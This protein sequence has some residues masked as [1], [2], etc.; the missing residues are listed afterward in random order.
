MSLETSRFPPPL[1]PPVFDGLGTLAS[2][3]GATQVTGFDPALRDADPADVDFA[4]DPAS[5][6]ITGE[7]TQQWNTTYSVSGEV[8]VSAPGLDAQVVPVRYEVTLRNEQATPAQMRA[9]HPFDPATI[10]DRTRIEV[11]GRDYAGTPLEA[12]F[13][14]LA[15]ANGL[16]AIDDL[17]LSLE[18]TAD[19]TLRVMTG[20]NRL[21]DAPRDGG[22]ASLP[23]GREDFIRHTT[24]LDDPRG[25]DRAA[26]TRMLL[27]GTVPDDTV[28]IAEDVEGR[29]IT[30][31]VTEAGS[32]EANTV[33]WTLDASGRPVSADAVLTWEPGSGGRD[34]DR[35]E[36][37]AQSRFRSDNA[38]QGT[39]DD[40]GHMIAYRFV[41]G[42][43]PVN[44]FPQQ[45]QF[46]QRIYAGMEQEWSD[47]LA[48][49][50]E[51]RI[52]VALAPTDVR[53]PDQVRVDY[54]VIDPAN[55]RVVYDPVLIV[56]ENEAGQVFDR[57]ARNDMDDMI[58]GAS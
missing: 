29:A 54:A 48:E 20:A 9:I 26:Y 39:G 15:G 41:N 12:S 10:P 52:E 43:G 45:S 23:A 17:R 51:V 4:L 32:G 28:R 33:T 13:R 58:E 2:R 55:G 25:A 30:G 46:N 22:P 37:N 5:V 38:M 35:I 1:P 27:D 31:V 24:L 40:V 49:G 19:G 47:W 57:I 3:F 42:H 44:M 11:Q 53:R 18:M 56:F 50:M 36:A 21:F 34:S 6:R 8:Q 14:A 7:N 16:D